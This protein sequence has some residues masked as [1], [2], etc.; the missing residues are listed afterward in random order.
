LYFPSFSLY[1]FRKDPSKSYQGSKIVQGPVVEREQIFIRL[2]ERI[3]AYATSRICRDVA[4]DLTQDTLMLLHE[5]YASVTRIEDLVPLAIR[6]MRFK[7]SAAWR[8][9]K[10]RGENDALPVEDLPLPDFRQNPGQGAERNEFLQRLQSAM[11][12]LSGRCREMF[13]YKLEGMDFPE[14]ARR[15]GVASLNTVYTWDHRCRDRLRDLMGE[16]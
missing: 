10:R 5:K 1:N 16:P 4:E 7:V 12:K 13:L 15:M 2:R 9:T 11:V 3:L 14:I 6:I 8:K